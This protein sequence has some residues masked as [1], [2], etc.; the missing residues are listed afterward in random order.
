MRRLVLCLAALAAGLATAAGLAGSG[1][2]ATRHYWVVSLGDSYTSGNGA[3]NYY[4]TDNGCHRSYDSYPWR[5]REL[6]IASGAT[7]DNWHVAC[8]GSVIADLTHPY[9]NGNGVSMPA[10]LNGVPSDVASSADIAV[11]TIGGNDLGFS[12]IAIDCLTNPLTFFQCGSRLNTAMNALPSVIQRT[13]DALVAVAARMPKAQ[14]VLVGYPKLTSPSCALS[15]WNGTIST[16]QD[17]FDSQ[18]ATA[19]A[20]LNL[21]QHTTRYHFLKISPAFIG[22]GPCASTSS[23]YIHYIVLSRSWETFH[24]TKTGHQVIANSLRA[25]SFLR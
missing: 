10:Q 21:A 11:L 25:A 3:G 18:Q 9:T 14:V 6:L 5:F 13:S 23:Q 8:S 20:N 7:A 17:S 16:L 24:P 19:V 12:G 4:P 15:P 1:H 22:H 2:S